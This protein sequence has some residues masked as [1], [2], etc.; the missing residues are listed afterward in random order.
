M[1]VK[2][3]WPSRANLHIV[4]PAEAQTLARLPRSPETED[5]ESVP[6]TD[7]AASSSSVS[8]ISSSYKQGPVQP[9]ISC[10]KKMQIGMHV[11]SFGNHW[12]ARYPL[13]EYSVANDAVFYFL[14]RHFK[15]KSCYADA[16][17]V[18]SGCKNWKKLGYKLDKHNESLSHMEALEQWSLAKQAAAMGN[19]MDKIDKHHKQ[20][21]ICNWEAA[22]SLICAALFCARQSIALKGHRESKAFDDEPG[23]NRGNFAELLKLLVRM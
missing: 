16:L 12:Y 4:R 14:C 2:P 15:P 1:S 3:S 6:T 22:V 13:T 11:R 20:D 8:D 5:T 17:F 7:L 10:F 18:D 23:S 21:V 19:V 9:N